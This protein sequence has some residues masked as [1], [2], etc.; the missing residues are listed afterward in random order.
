M[1]DRTKINTYRGIDIYECERY[2]EDDYRELLDDIYGGVEIAGLTYSTSDALESVD[3]V[4]FRC[5]FSDAQE[6]YYTVDHEDLDGEEY[7][8]ERDAID[9]IDELLSDEDEDE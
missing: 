9:T 7:D 8:D 6:Y 4:A 5:G 1:T 2:D 3:P